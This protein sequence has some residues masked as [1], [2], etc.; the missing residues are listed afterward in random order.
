MSESLR[1]GAEPG[2]GTGKKGGAADRHGGNHV[3]R[4]GCPRSISFFVKP[5]V[6]GNTERYVENDA[7]A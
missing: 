6:A 7:G 4:H 1:A 3:C 5:K 2:G